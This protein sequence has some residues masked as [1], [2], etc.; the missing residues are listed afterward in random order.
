MSR[1]CTICNRADRAE[2]EAS[3]PEKS[4]AQ[5]GRELPL[6]KSSV[7]IHFHN[8]AGVAMSDGSKAVKKEPEQ[9]HPANWR[10]GV[11]YNPE[12]GTG[13]L[14]GASEKL[15]TTWDFI[16]Q[17]WGLD[18]T[19][20]EVVPGSVQIRA[21]DAG[22][23]RLTYYRARLQPVTVSKEE[24]RGAAVAELVKFIHAKRPV[25]AKEAV[26]DSAFV[27][28]LSDWQIGKAHEARGGTDETVARYLS[29]LDGAVR[30]LRT[31]IKEGHKIDSIVLAGLGDLV[32]GCDGFYAMQSFTVDRNDREQNTIV[33][34]LLIKT[35]DEFLF[36]GLPI[37]CLAVPGNHGENRRKGKAFT[38]LTDNRDL[39]AF[40]VVSEVLVQNPERYGRVTFPTD[41]LNDDDLTATLEIHG[42]PVAFSHGHQAKSGGG[43]QAKTEGWWKG[44]VMGFTGIANARILF[45]AHFHHFMA[46]TQSGR[47]VIQNGAMDGGSRWHK[48]ST[49]QEAHAGMVSCLVG[50]SVGPYGW[51]DLYL[52]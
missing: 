43:S 8:H 23:K 22:N 46:S 9:S 4:F 14:I 26:G 49:G 15:P 25:K 20:V 41:L 40:E 28:L 19:E 44:Q 17:E 38:D 50:E 32:E 42:V 3:Y 24:E 33:R 7:A 27:V 12:T 11:E 30:R 51:S 10:P 21:W 48:A 37:V 2:I 1:K 6:D 16:L 31:L 52:H 29:A 36:F 47:T 5:I 13:S 35:I 18:P 39:E 34:H 45:T